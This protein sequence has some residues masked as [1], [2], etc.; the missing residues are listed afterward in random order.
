MTMMMVMK[1]EDNNNGIIAL[2]LDRVFPHD[3]NYQ[4]IGGSAISQQ[5]P[6]GFFS[7]VLPFHTYRTITFSI[8]YPNKPPLLQK[9]GPSVVH[10]GS[11]TSP[12]ASS[13]SALSGH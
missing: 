3:K 6:R 7:R 9:K 2:L 8:T 1:E 13:V 12:S 5:K 10:E 4:L 11:H